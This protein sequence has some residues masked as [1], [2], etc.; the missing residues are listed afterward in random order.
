MIILFHLNFPFLSHKA[1][2]PCATFSIL[3]ATITYTQIIPRRGT[4]VSS[5]VGFG[6]VIP[7]CIFY[8]PFW[9]LSTLDIR[10]KLLR[11]CISA[12]YPVLTIFKTSEAVFGF[13]PHSVESSYKNYILYYAT[14]VEIEYDKRKLRPVA[15]TF[16]EK[17]TS[18]QN[19]LMCLVVLGLYK[20]IFGPYNYEPF[21]T[22]A[23]GNEPGYDWKDIF[24][25]NLLC[26][27]F[28]STMLLQLYLTTFIAA[29]SVMVKIIFRVKVQEGV[30]KNPLMKAS[31]PSDFWGGRWNLLVHGVLKRGVFKPVYSVSSK[32]IAVLATFL[33]SGLFHEYILIGESVIACLFELSITE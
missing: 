28:V 11:F 6:V 18:L 12:I 10:N 32:L 19:F 1:V 20:S 26:N 8:F 30:M 15:A 29:L 25:L 31:S 17:V 24:D 16:D 27:N 3:M 23:N 5:L 33:A 13:S 2:I 14:G 4:F 21:Q 9:I 7:L 22:T